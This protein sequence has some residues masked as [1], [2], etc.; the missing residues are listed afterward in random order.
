MQGRVGNA[1]GGTEPMQ[2]G[3][4]SALRMGSR[5]GGH[6]RDLALEEHNQICIFQGSPRRKVTWRTDRLQ[7]GRPV[8]RLL[9][10]TR[11]VTIRDLQS[12]K[13]I[14]PFLLT[15][16]PSHH[17]RKPICWTVTTWAQNSHILSRITRCHTHK[18]KNGQTTQQRLLSLSCHVPL[19]NSSQCWH[20][21]V[22][23]SDKSFQWDLYPV[24]VQ[25]KQT[26][27]YS[28]VKEA[29]AACP[30]GQ[31]S[32]PPNRLLLLLHHPLGQGRTEKW[33]AVFRKATWHKRKT[34]LGSGIPFAAGSLCWL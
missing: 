24:L 22:R 31:V 29:L 13:G 9:Q 15:F 8:C 5:I 12:T 27:C 17:Q 1:A 33:T 30:I 4:F 21:G 11:W 23:S 6:W 2:E 20:P 7:E 18:Y 25:K 28:P 14:A 19:P 26:R 32:W 16:W 34:N 10:Y 3:S